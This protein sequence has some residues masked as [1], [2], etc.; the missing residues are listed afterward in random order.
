MKQF[1][2]QALSERGEPSIKRL[3]LAWSLILFTAELVV[4]AVGKQRVLDGTLQSQ[5][6]E[7]VLVCL[8][9]VLGINVLNGIKD[10]KFRQSDNNKAVGEPSPTPSTTI[11]TPEK[12]TV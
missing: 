5:L 4:N 1:I 10:I 9:A 12:S 6:Y 7:L 11:V 2:K 8:G 3:A